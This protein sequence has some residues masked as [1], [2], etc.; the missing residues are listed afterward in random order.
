MAWR[1]SWQND[2]T[3]LATE[4]ERSH[5]FV[6]HPFVT[7]TR[8]PNDRT[9]FVCHRHTK[10]F[11]SHCGGDPQCY[12]N[13]VTQVIARSKIPQN[14]S[15]RM[16]PLCHP[17]DRT[18][19]SK[20]SHRLTNWSHRF[21]SNWSHHLTFENIIIRKRETKTNF[22]WTVW[23]YYNYKTKRKNT[24]VELFENIIIRKRNENKLSLNFLKIL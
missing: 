2:R 22:R 20:R 10:R 7:W 11:L 24:F 16:Y 8:W 4:T 15:D 14:P 3:D 5:G 6:G 9:V 19:L 18:V 21:L 1:A 23:K 12:K 13:F 17:N